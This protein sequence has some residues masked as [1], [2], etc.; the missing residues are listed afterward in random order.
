MNIYKFFIYFYKR[1]QEKDKPDSNRI[2]FLEG[3][4]KQKKV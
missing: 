1:T 3:M 2:F 4:Q